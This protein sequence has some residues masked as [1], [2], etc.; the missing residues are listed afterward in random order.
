MHSLHRIVHRIVH[1]LG[2]MLRRDLSTVSI[3]DHFA[4][5]QPRRS[6][7]RRELVRQGLGGLAIV[8]S[9]AP[10]DGALEPRRNAQRTRG[11]A[12]EQKGACGRR[13]PW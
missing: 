11:L 8:R 9:R 1:R 3:R 7:M 6:H 2:V 5:S 13:G 4:V 10:N 12:D